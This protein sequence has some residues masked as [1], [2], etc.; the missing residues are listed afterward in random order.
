MYK[1]VFTGW[2]HAYQ[3]FGCIALVSVI[4]SL[5]LMILY[6]FVWRENGLLRKAIISSAF[7]SGIV[8]L[9]VCLSLCLSLS[10]SVS[11][12]VSLSLHH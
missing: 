8:T 6:M 10:V 11:V 1:C 7:A 3:T 5:V 2:V 4:V 9:F 12:S